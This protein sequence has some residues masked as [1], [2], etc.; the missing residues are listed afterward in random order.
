MCRQRF[1][2]LRG[3]DTI[4]HRGFSHA[5]EAHNI[6]SFRTLNGLLRQ[7][8]KGENLGHAKALDLVSVP[9]E[10]F[11]GFACFHGAR[12]DA[13]GQDPTNERVRA[14][15]RGQHAEG[16]I[17]AFQLGRCRDVINDQVKKCGKVLAGA[18]EFHIC[19][20]AAARSIHGREIQLIVVR[21]EIGKK[22]ET[23]IQSAIGF[24]VR[25]VDLVE[26]YNRAQTQSQCLGCH[27]FG[28][29]HRAFCS[30]DQKDNAIHHGQDTFHFAAKIR[31]PGR[32]DDIDANPFPLNRCRLGKDGYSALALKVVAV[33]GTLGRGLVVAVGS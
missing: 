12:L 27:E 1:A 13:S 31:V 15:R 20:A 18:I 30:V 5:G 29:G 11:D 3:N 25:L 26:H 7:P 6:S 8:P 16:L 22:V 19:P 9:A 2:D 21:A 14:Q 32:V 23:L 24:G 28:L 17:T 10:R 33:H 4:G